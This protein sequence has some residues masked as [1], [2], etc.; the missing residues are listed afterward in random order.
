MPDQELLDDFLEALEQ[1]GSPVK[2]PVLRQ[3]LGWEEATYEAVK[4]QLVAMRIVVLT[5]S[6]HWQVIN[7]SDHATRRT[8]PPTGRSRP[9]I[10][11]EGGDT[12]SPCGILDRPR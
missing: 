3:R 5:P 9:T 6:R 4:A 1:S 7:A 8:S 10:R 12:A 2:N 11:F